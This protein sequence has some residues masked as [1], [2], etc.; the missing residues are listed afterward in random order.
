MNI[1][2]DDVE[3]LIDQV[4]KYRVNKALSEAEKSIFKA[5]GELREDICAAESAVEVV[6]VR[7]LSRLSRRYDKL[8]GLL[9]AEGTP[10]DVVEAFEPMRD[11]LRRRLQVLRRRHLETF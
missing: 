5:Y 2:L 3:S 1:G 4:Y 9:D 8:C 10:P 11:E 7:G 6:I